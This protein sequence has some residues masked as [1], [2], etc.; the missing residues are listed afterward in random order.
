MRVREG[1]FLLQIKSLTITHR[2]D[3][4]TIIQNFDFVLNRGDK[5]V[6]IG[7]EGNGKSTLLKWIYDPKLVKSY[8]EADGIR[9]LQGELIGYLPQELADEEK[10]KTVYDYFSE[11]LMFQETNLYE[12]EKLAAEIGLPSTF[13]YTDQKMQS[14]SGGERV[15][16]QMARLLLVHPDILLL[17]E[18]SNDID[19]ST[20]RWLE[21]TINRFK[22]SVLFISHDEMLIERTA[23]RVILLEQLRR[24]SMPRVT[25][26][27]MPFRTF[28]EERQR[29]FD[30]QKQEA[31]SER[32]EE[33]KAMERF[34][35][36]EQTVESDLRNISRQDPHGG[37][38]LKKKMK[39]VKSLEKRYDRERGGMTE[40]PEMESPITIR[41]EHQRPMPA[42]KNVL[43]Y[44]LPELIAPDGRRLAENVCLKVRGPNKVCIIGDNGTGKTTLIRKI[45]KEL[46]PRQDLNIFYMSQ[47]YEETLPF[48]RT[49]T[50]YLAPSGKKDDVTMVRT[51]L[52]S[53]KY[54]ADEMSHSIRELSGGQKAKL[55]LLKI[56]LTEANVLILDEPTRNFSPLS[57]ATVRAVLKQFPG[58]IISISH[59]RKYISE[60]CNT[61]YRLTSKV[62]EKDEKQAIAWMVR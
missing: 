35:R 17:D 61:V 31:C 5:A 9:A 59:D 56:S 46:L 27:N 36:I 6:L 10:E 41:F 1:R 44:N 29:A 12:L 30:K 49:P 16:I 26:A 2:K 39:A 25:V 58:T 55:L 62:L 32:R 50:E 15:K 53:M 40:V 57:G 23:N 3:L 7:E 21:D 47:N 42:G 8:A 43:E 33:K 34:R 54:T 45:A 18:P 11:Q 51:Y 24:K 13:I 38:L 52:G 19:L 20:L 4:R 22:G 37:Q 14:L 28:M 60:V 48:D